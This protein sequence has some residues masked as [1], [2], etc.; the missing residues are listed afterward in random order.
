MSSGIIAEYPAA[1]QQQHSAT[2]TASE[3]VT[4]LYWGK[5]EFASVGSLAVS[6]EPQWKMEG[7]F[8]ITN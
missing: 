7:L 3:N 5:N 6:Q 8:C 4:D 1:P 2:I